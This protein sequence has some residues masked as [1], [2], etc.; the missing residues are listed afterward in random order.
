MH[1]LS[2]AWTLLE[3]FMQV[4]HWLVVYLA[5]PD[6]QTKETHGHST[7]KCS[8]SDFF[9]FFLAKLCH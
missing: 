3:F 8:I 9:S 1:T 2:P 7:F 4:V 6:G 5:S